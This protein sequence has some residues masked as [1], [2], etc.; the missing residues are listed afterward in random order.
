MDELVKFFASLPMITLNSDNQ[1]IKSGQETTRKVSGSPARALAAPQ[2]SVLRK[3]DTAAL[4]EDLSD[5]PYLTHWLGYGRGVS[6]RMRS[7]E[8]EATLLQ[9]V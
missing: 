4:V 6:A 3:R 7:G 1:S 8:R 9:S 5:N 2:P